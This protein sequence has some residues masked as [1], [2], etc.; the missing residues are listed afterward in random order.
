M[1]SIRKIFRKNLVFVIF[2]S[3]LGFVAFVA[4]SY[5]LILPRFL[6]LLTV[7]LENEVIKIEIVDLEK[8]IRVTKAIDEKESSKFFLL[9]DNLVPESEDVV[10]SITLAEKVAKISGVTLTSFDTN[11]EQVVPGQSV[12][13]SPQ[14]QESTPT[15]SVTAIPTSS[16]SYEI[17][18]T[19]NGSFSGVTNFISNFLKTD[20]LLGIG[21]VTLGSIGSGI[22]AVLKV[23]FSLS[24]STATIELGDDLVLTEAE[25]KQLKEIEGKKFSASPSNDPLGPADPFK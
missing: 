12:T 9:V 17:E 1:K 20:R 5:L 18:V 15:Q 25:K 24:P 22:S 19:V 13:A 2:F 3:V 11:P 16:S 10:R 4:V 6:S 8:N 23:E 21:D 14:E 7:K